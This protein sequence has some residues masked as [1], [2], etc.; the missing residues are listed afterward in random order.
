MHFN[1]N[2]YIP[3]KHVIFSTYLFLLLC[4]C[5]VCGSA[6][7]WH[8]AGTTPQCAAK[9]RCLHHYK[10]AGSRLLMDTHV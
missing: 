9:W 3:Y 6:A 5:S 4:G 1:K 8:S 2:T 10:W 7:C